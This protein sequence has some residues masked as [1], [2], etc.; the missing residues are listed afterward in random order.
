[1]RL[2][3]D[4]L[5]TPSLDS[6][7]IFDGNGHPSWANAA[8]LSGSLM[9]GLLRCTQLYRRSCLFGCRVYATILHGRLLRR[10][11]IKWTV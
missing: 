4:F 11:Y 3:A 5:E 6:V 9:Y 2:Q 10:A 1:M 8:F 7:G